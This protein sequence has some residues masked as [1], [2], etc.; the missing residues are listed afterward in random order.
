MNMAIL[1]TQVY[2][3]I[4][5]PISEK[6]AINLKEIEPLVLEDLVGKNI[7]NLDSIT[8]ESYARN[9]RKE[10]MSLN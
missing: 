4:V 7:L 9:L 3:N 8:F 1:Q 5:R 6:M 10:Q 2:A